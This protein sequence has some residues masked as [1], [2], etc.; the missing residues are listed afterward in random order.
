[1]GRARSSGVPAPEGPSPA[2]VRGRITECLQRW[3][4]PLPQDSAGDRLCPRGSQGI[5]VALS[6]LLAD[7]SNATRT[8]PSDSDEAHEPTRAAEAS[9][10]QGECCQV[11]CP[12][13]AAETPRPCQEGGRQ[14]HGRVQTTGG[15]PWGQDTGKVGKRRDYSAA[16]SDMETREQTDC[17]GCT[18]VQ[19][20]V[21]RAG[22]RIGVGRPGAAGG[23]GWWMAGAHTH[24][25]DTDNVR[26]SE[27]WNDV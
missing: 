1:M 19:P 2:R 26:L 24:Y 25:G 6:W 5:G 12:G 9:A 20:G 7:D 21:L 3:N 14:P 4:R 13:T 10:R 8:G 22:D 23:I 17:G 27:R 15:L 16:T 11:C 18:V